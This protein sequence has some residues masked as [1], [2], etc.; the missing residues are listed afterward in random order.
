MF[1]LN[2]PLEVNMTLS[3]RMFVGSGAVGIASLAT[4]SVS[5]A[6]VSRD[7]DVPTTLDLADAYFKSVANSLGKLIASDPAL[8]G[9][10]DLDGLEQLYPAKFGSEDDRLIQGA[11]Y[12][13]AR[14]LLA[15]VAIPP[16][17]EELRARLSKPLA[18]DRLDPNYFR[19]V[20]ARTKNRAAGDEN[21]AREVREA[22][23]VAV[24]L[25]LSVPCSGWVR[26]LCLGVAVAIIVLVVIVLL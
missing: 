18:V 7:F 2:T 15:M 5:K 13:Q 12:L 22:G 17:T 24:A 4:S 20:L 16:S 10:H 11:L 19:D 9:L 1:P 3:R 21:Y 8:P 23:N 6:A 26:W 25:G 14:E